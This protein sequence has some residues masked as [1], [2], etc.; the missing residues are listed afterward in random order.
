M[1]LDISLSVLQFGSTARNQ[2]KAIYRRVGSSCHFAVVLPATVLVALGTQWDERGGT[3]VFKVR[4]EVGLKRQIIRYS[5]MIAF[6][7][8]I[9]WNVVW[10]AKGKIPPSILLSA[11]GL[12][13]P[14]TGCIRS[15]HALCRGD[16]L[17][18]F[19]FN[20]LTLVYLVLLVYTVL[21]LTVHMVHGE[22]LV[23]RPCMG[24]LWWASLAVGWAAKFALG[25]SFW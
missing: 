10:I 15:L 18:S 1:H 21:V 2:E 9:A 8:Y 22:R 7:A 17:H 11:F 19:L 25:R 3:V 12:P 4:H 16:L 13:C 6:G 5:A 23:L 20:P 24:W 14:T